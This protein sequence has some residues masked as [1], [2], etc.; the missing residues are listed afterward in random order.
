MSPCVLTDF[1]ILSGWLAVNIPALRYQAVSPLV[2]YAQPDKPKSQLVLEAFAV[3]SGARMAWTTEVALLPGDAA[4]YGVRPAWSHLW[5]QAKRE[6]RNWWYLDNSYFDVTRERYF[7]VTKNAIQHDG[8]GPSDGRRFNKLGIPI[9]AMRGGDYELVCQQSDE[10]MWVVADDP[11]WTNRVVS[12]LREA[13]KS[14]VIRRKN[15]K[16]PLV[17]DLRRARRLWTFSSAAAVTALLEGVPVSTSG[18]SC[19]HSTHPDD[20]L[21]WAGVLADNQF[22]VDE[23]KNGLA[24]KSLNG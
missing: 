1:L 12:R 16:T 22:S 4:F 14:V 8:R 2:C 15:S 23:M 18:M 6:R 3:G 5:E 10:F 9:K 13:G 7:R 17:E 21:R 24:W 20:R 11:D 19:A